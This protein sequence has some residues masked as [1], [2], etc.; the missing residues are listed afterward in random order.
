MLTTLANLQPLPSGGADVGFYN[1]WIQYLSPIPHIFLTLVMLFMHAIA[2]IWYYLGTG[3]LEAYQAGF[4]LLPFVSIF[5][6][7]NNAAYQT[8]NLGNIVKVF[9]YFGFVIFGIMML[10][11][12]IKYTATAGKKGR[13][14]PK[15]ITITMATLIALPW[16]IG[17]MSDVGTS[18]VDSTMGNK[19]S[20]IMTQIWQGNSTNLSILAQNNFDLDAYKNDPT[21]KITDKEITGGN[22]HS[23]MSDPGYT[24]GLNN[25][26]KKVFTKKIGGNDKIADLDGSAPILGKTF[27]DE[28]PVMKTN[29]LGIIAG[30]IVFIIVVVSAMI[31]LLSSIYKMAFMS[32][33]I[34]YFG[35]R[36]GTQGKRVMEVL[37]MIE[38]Q[39]TGI[40]MMPI[41]LIFFFTWVD[42]AFNMINEMALTVWPFTLLSIAILLSGAKGLAAGFEM[43]EQ[44]TGVRSGHNPVASMM[45]AGQ[46]ANMFS[47]VGQSAKKNIGGGLKAIS[48]AQRQKS[49]EK[50]QKIAESA[51]DMSMPGSEPNSN[52]SSTPTPSSSKVAGAASAL[53]RTVGAVKKPGALA[54]NTGRAAGSKIKSGFNG[55]VDN[56]KNYAGTVGDSYSGG[57]QSVDAFNQRHTPVK[58][59][60]S[61]SST[62]SGEPKNA[63]EALSQLSENND[64]VSPGS[65]N[66]SMAQTVPDRTQSQGVPV[67]QATGGKMSSSQWTALLS[68]NKSGAREVPLPRASTPQTITSGSNSK[69][70]TVQSGVNVREVPLPTAAAPTTTSTRTPSQSAS[71]QSAMS[72]G[73]IST[74]SARN[75][76]TPPQ[77]PYSNTTANV[78]EIPLPSVSINA[79]GVNSLNS[80]LP[81]KPLSAE[82]KL[83][84]NTKSA[85]DTLDQVINDRLAKLKEKSEHKD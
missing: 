28:Y 74:Q 41:S 42:F 66:V 17:I 1:D 21:N 47:K 55:A 24:D 40:V 7:P 44:W 45:L 33:S 16:A 26:Q 72:A 49:R 80:S 2:L 6:D 65:A 51:N 30:E 25:D 12:W 62:G 37:G 50:G 54:K 43:I 71:S 13:E 39:I 18:A 77:T 64:T 10:V 48:P 83:A 67:Q 11:Q 5:F 82:E 58:A 76:V 68:G 20:N 63:H 15:G 22:F 59:N 61:G 31:R 70:M 56:V 8:W 27:T 78:R 84:N 19:S 79:S 73:S 14:W 57:K 38:G 46:A 53:G 36:D 23:V 3:V 4:K 81:N 34:I 32:G 35:L 52:V 9:L 75:S 85:S 60:L 69:N 29:W